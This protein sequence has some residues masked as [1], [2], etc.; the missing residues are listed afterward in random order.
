MKPFRHFQLANLIK[1]ELG[2]IFLRELDLAPKIFLTI[3]EV[4]MESDLSKASVGIKVFPEQKTK[5]VLEMLKKEKGFLKKKLAAKIRI[6]F[7]PEI[8]F[9][10]SAW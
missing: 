6:K 8:E 3:E 2:E 7:F 10:I 5:E 1:K 9:K 4:D